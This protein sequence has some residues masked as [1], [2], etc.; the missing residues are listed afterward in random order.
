MFGIFF[1]SKAAGWM[2][3][4]DAKKRAKN[5]EKQSIFNKKL[6]DIELPG[7]LSMFNE[8]MVSTA[9]LMTI[10]FG[11]ILVIIGPDFLIEL[12]KNK[13]L[14]GNA[15]LKQGQDFF[16]YVLY[17]CFQFAVYLTI[18]QLGVRTFVAELTTSFQGISNKL[19]K[20][21]VPGVDCAV[22]FGFGSTNAVTIGFL[23]GAVDSRR[24]ALGLIQ[25]N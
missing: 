5:P 18:L 20:G 23:A 10:F 13:T 11:I 15:A 25:L 22:T 14:T 12:T 2:A 6:E 16:F 17:N 3:R 8:N 1:A 9:I 19:I 7:W 21:S 4:R 24:V